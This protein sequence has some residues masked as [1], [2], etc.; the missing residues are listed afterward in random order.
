MNCV[1]ITYHN[2]KTRI[3]PQKAQYHISVGHENPPLDLKE[4]R[5]NY[6]L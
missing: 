3:V 5:Q 2:Q 1:V 4:F 6:G